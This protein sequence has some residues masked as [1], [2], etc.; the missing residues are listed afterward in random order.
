MLTEVRP[1][2]NNRKVKNR[3]KCLRKLFAL[4]EQYPTYLSLAETEE[5]E[6]MSIINLLKFLNAQ[7]VDVWYNDLSEI[8]ARYVYEHY[9]MM[10]KK[11]NRIDFHRQSR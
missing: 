8:S 7:Y 1:K 11:N 2:Q 10:V 6:A 9:V 3:I 4:Q 5:M